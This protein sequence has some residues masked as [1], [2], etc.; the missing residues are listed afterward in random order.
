V[1]GDVD[2]AS[3]LANEARVS[4]PTISGHLKKLVA[5]T[6]MTTSADGSGS[7]SCAPS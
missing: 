1:D 3:V 4:A 2:I 5:A 6:A 7:R